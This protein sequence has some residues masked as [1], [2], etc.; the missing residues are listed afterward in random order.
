MKDK[1]LAN[2]S[3]KIELLNT[4]LTEA[5]NENKALQAK[6]SNVRSAPP[7]VESVQASKA[8]GSA[9]KGKGQIRTVMVGSAEAAQAAQIAQLKEDL[10]S[11]LTGLLLRGVEKGEEENVYDCIQTGRNGSKSFSTCS[12]ATRSAKILFAA[13]HFKIAISND[14]DTAYDDAEVTYTPLL[15]TNRDRDILQLMPDYLTE[16]ITFSR[17]HAAHFYSKVAETLMKKQR[18]MSEE[19]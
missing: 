12:A 3:A 19:P 9:V 4:S 11:D 6:L 16:E 13:L 10:Y 2:A 8:P 14:A 15:D 1:D 5:Q 18:V 7:V 17:N